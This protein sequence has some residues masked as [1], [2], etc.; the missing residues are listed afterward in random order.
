MNMVSIIVPV[1]NC[2]A[3]LSRSIDSILAQT[4]QDFEVILVDDGSK[5]GSSQICDEYARLDRRVKVLHKDNGGVSAARNSGIRIATGE[6]I[7]FVDADDRIAPDMYAELLSAAQD[8]NSDIAYCDFHIEKGLDYK[9]RKQPKY[10]GDNI[11]LINDFMLGGWTS[12]WNI[13][14]SR[15]FI[16]QNRLRFDE[17]LKY[18]EDFVFLIQALMNSNN[19]V[20]VDKPLYYYN[21]GNQEGAINSMT[22]AD[23][24]YILSSIEKVGNFARQKGVFGQIEKTY[25]WK[26]IAAK[27]DIVFKRECQKDFLTICPESHRYIFSCPW[28]SI[29]MKI[30]MWLA[31]RGRGSI[32][33]LIN[34]LS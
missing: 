23:F 17:E 12:V 1:Y 21:R 11:L 34:L 24:R 27:Q 19:V 31:T 26:I 5:D 16:N 7:G 33:K 10:A 29:K 28:L 9:Q 14:V 30:L 8:T 13:L 25:Y 3:Y 18:C 20:Y 32:L 15:S 2:E 6:W 22:S 4:V